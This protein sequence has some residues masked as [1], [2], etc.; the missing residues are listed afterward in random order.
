MRVHDLDA[1]PPQPAR[2]AGDVERQQQPLVK[3]LR[4]HPDTGQL[5]PFEHAALLGRHQPH[6]AATSLKAPQLRQD[7]MLLTAPSE[8]RL[9]V[10]DAPR[11]PLAKSLVG[12]RRL[13]L[14]QN[15]MK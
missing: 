3:P 10:D 2:H 4:L 7:T 11:V 12:H 1:V 8:R 13:Y 14:R 9:G 15:T 5:R 6:L